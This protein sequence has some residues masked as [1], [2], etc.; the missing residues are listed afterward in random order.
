MYLKNVMQKLSLI[1]LLI[2]MSL[3]NLFADE[4]VTMTVAKW[5]SHTSEE[6]NHNF[7][8]YDAVK[9]ALNSA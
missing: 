6:K 4:I 2:V 1:I 7:T 8:I 5:T 9:T 3:S